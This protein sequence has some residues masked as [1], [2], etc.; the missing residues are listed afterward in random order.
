M[1]FFVKLKAV[2]IILER[3]GLSKIVSKIVALFRELGLKG[4]LSKLRH[5]FVKL[6]IKDVTID[7]LY[8]ARTEKYISS[9]PGIKEDICF[10]IIMPIYNADLSLLQEAIDSIQEQSYSNWQICLADDKSSDEKIKPYLE[11][12]TDSS[13]RIDLVFRDRNGHIS[14]ASNSCLELAK[15][16]Y[17]VLMDQDDLLHKDALLA[18]AHHIRLKPSASLLYSDEDKIDNKQRFFQPHFKT[19]FNPDLFFSQNYI[20]HIGIYRRELIEQIGG[21]REGY[22]GAQDFDLALRVVKYARW[23]DIIHM[24]Y[25]LYHWRAL[26]GSTALLA[27][28]KK[29]SVEAGRKALLSYFE[30]DAR[31][32]H[33]ENSL[34]PNTYKVNWNISGNPL[35]DIIIPTRDNKIL[36]K[37]CIDSVILKTRY[38]NYQITIVDNA[39]EKLETKTYLDEISK[40]QN[41]R[42]L[43]YEEPFNFSAI[44]NF[45]VNQSDADFV[46]LLN[47]DTQVITENWLDEMLALGQRDFCGC[48]GAKLLFGDNTLQHAGVILGLLG[49]ANHSHLGF[50]DSDPGY[51][52]R[53]TIRQNVSAVTGACLLVKRSIY[54]EV[55]GLDDTNLAVAFNDIDFCIRVMQQGYYNVF[56]PYAKLY[57]YESKS[58]GKDDTLKKADRFE[59]EVNYML[60]TWGEVLGDDPFY[61]QHLTKTDMDFSPNLVL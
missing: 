49:V 48:V 55:G 42:I 7:A 46:L 35:V 44:N 3:Y 2:V 30:N 37:Q 19:S 34:L 23:E 17:I 16:E 9:L 52:G 56:T 22:E 12:L 6:V 58:R 11:S 57:H 21:F 20:S 18:A 45:A 26:P 54:N 40:L 38:D 28:E 33:V 5:A 13:T 29:Y 51:F 53:L 25:V 27:G 61:S 32:D 31:V 41:I 59:S 50:K 1:R 36:L 4:M 8:N 10:S 43:L 24:P 60:D 47:N 15:G 14:A 39:S